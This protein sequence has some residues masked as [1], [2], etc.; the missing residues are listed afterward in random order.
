MREN[1]ESTPPDVNGLSQGR[2]CGQQSAGRWWRQMRYDLPETALFLLVSR[3][4][5]F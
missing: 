5:T 2:G 3:L 1:T 4:R